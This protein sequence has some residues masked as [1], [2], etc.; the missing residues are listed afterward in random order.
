M[1]FLT[2]LYYIVSC[3][4]N[5]N[6]GH[7]TTSS[8]PVQI[9]QNNN[10]NINYKQAQLINKKS[11][12]QQRNTY[13]DIHTY[14]FYIDTLNKYQYQ[15]RSEAIVSGLSLGNRS[16]K[17]VKISVIY[18]FLFY[19]MCANILLHTTI[20]HLLTLLTLTTLHIQDSSRWQPSFYRLTS[21]CLETGVFAM[22][23]N[24]RAMQPIMNSVV[25]F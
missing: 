9:R 3:N 1:I 7:F 4:D 11:R 5:I 24:N 19:Y 2:I 21:I 25:T 17:C 14:K 20:L 10:K 12:D 23:P 15:I 16:P 6:D 8:S 18:L 22:S 13:D